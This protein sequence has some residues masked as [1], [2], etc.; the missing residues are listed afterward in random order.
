MIFLFIFIDAS[1]DSCCIKRKSTTLS[2]TTEDTATDGASPEKK[3][4]LDE[5]CAETETNGDA[6]ATA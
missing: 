4:K 5:K 2:E 1:V 6:E 3:K